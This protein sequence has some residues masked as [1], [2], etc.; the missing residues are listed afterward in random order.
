MLSYNFHIP[1]I[2]YIHGYDSYRSYQATSTHSYRIW[3][4]NVI[5]PLATLIP[6]MISSSYL[7]LDIIYTPDSQIYIWSSDSSFEFQTHRSRRL[8][9]NS[10]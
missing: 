8:F 9:D 7:A 1:N 4:L 5:F 6:L 3:S 10:I 2:N